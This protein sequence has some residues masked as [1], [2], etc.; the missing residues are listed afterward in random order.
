MKER[1]TQHRDTMR[2]SYGAGIV[3]NF[4]GAKLEL[5]YCIPHWTQSQDKVRIL[6]DSVPFPS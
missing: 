5:N 1:I 2:M 3:T 6:C 4:L